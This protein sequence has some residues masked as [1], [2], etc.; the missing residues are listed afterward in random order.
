MNPVKIQRPSSCV[1]TFPLQK[2]EK[3]KES[4]NTIKQKQKRKRKKSPCKD[5]LGMYSDGVPLISIANI[6]NCS[7]VRSDK[8]NVSFNYRSLNK[9]LNDNVLVQF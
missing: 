2:E 6:W 1:P 3:K 4:K 9:T 8:L 5:T 7:Q